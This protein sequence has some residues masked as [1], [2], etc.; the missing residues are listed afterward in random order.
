MTVP[1]VSVVMPSYNHARF[2]P[3]AIDSVLAQDDPGLELV[4]IDGGSDDGSVDILAS[5]GDRL[6]FVSERDRGQAA[7]INRGFTLARGEILGW[8]NSDDLLLP[9]VVSAVVGVFD[10]HPEADFV[11]GR[12]WDIDEHGRVLEESGVL[13]FDLWRL[14]HQRNFIHQPSCFFRR[15]LFERAGPIDES[16]N[17]VLDWDLWIRFAGAPRLKVDEF[18]SCNRVYPGNKTQSG[19]FR[20]WA[21]IRRMVRRY[22]ESSWPPVVW[23]YLLEALGQRVRARRGPHAVERL[24]G[25]VLT[26]GMRRDMSGRYADGGVAPRFRFSVGNPGGRR[27][28]RLTLSPLSRYDRSRRGAPPVS[29]RYRT[30][31]GGD[32]VFRLVENG[33]EQ[34]FTIATDRPAPFVHVTCRS[35]HPGVSLGGGGGL[36]RRRIVGF[37]DTVEV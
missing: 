37:L 30:S 15:D 34:P 18:W 23:L 24:L 8:L 3:A 29:I 26:R 2:L 33:A 20:R 32:G 17:Y 10:E 13:D 6:R 28:V 22:T 16:L 27:Q 11:Y 9:R 25:R 35:D 21:E 1:R 14:I 5:Y 4:V 12:G 7:A 31:A 19:E 36:P